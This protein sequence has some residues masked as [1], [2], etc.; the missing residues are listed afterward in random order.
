M[1]LHVKCIEVSNFLSM[2][3]SIIFSCPP[4]SMDF[5]CQADGRRAETQTERPE[6]ARLD[7]VPRLETLLV[8]ALAGDA[9]DGCFL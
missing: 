7:V 5:P 8:S 3:D 6:S 1:Y 2:Q 4:P 9:A